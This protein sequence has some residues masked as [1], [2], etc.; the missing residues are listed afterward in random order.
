MLS[1]KTLDDEEEIGD[2]FQRLEKTLNKIIT[3]IQNLSSDGH[4]NE[5]FQE[6]FVSSIRVRG[7]PI[8]PPLMTPGLCFRLRSLPKCY[9][10]FI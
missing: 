8:L 2:P 9:V 10:S 6:E 4:E 5:A 7:R 1:P 3:E